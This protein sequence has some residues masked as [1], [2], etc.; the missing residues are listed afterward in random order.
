MHD[1]SLHKRVG[2]LHL[3]ISP[4]QYFWVV[5][6][7]LGVTEVQEQIRVWSIT[8]TILWASG[9]VMLLIINAVFF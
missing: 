7:S 5:N 3:E 9:S 2:R 6:R 8:S 1:G 4:H